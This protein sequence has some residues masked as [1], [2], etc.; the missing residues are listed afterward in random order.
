[1][2]KIL[3]VDDDDD[4]RDVLHVFLSD[5]GHDVHESSD[6]QE[7]LAWLSRH[8]DA[9]PCVAIVDLRMPAV[10]G[11]DLLATV[12]RDP[13]WRKL[14]VV[15]LSGTIQRGEYPPVLEA[16]GFWSKPVELHRL[17]RVHK[18]CPAHRNTWRNKS[19]VFEG[20]VLLHRLPSGTYGLGA[21]SC[22]HSV[23]AV[24]AR[25]FRV[26][27][28]PSGELRIY[29]SHGDMTI[30]AAIQAGFVHLLAS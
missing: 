25:G 27:T 26:E 1:M 10:D 11:W 12:R 23:V 6:G 9:P 18:H 17:E 29:G 5:C 22:S 21:T 19:S 8:R 16:D 13:L 30:E 4:L 20:E 3:I 24:L 2:C 7:A 14:P 15:V 28:G